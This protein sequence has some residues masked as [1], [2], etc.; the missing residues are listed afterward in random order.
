MTSSQPPDVSL[1]D[2]GAPCPIAPVLAARLRESRDELTARWLERIVARVNLDPNRVFPTEELLDHVPMLLVGIA[3]YIENPANELGADVAVLAKA[4]ELGELRF[5]QGFDA[6]EILKEY[7]IFG[8]ILF[9]FLAREAEGAGGDCTRA[10]LMTCSHRLYRAISVVQR[11]TTIQYLR[12][13]GES[14]GEREDRLRAFHRA[15]S[16]EFKNQIHAALGASQALALEGIP[17]EDS[18]RLVSVVQDSMMAMRSRLEALLSLTAIESDSRRTRHVRLPQAVAEV[19]R[20]LREMASAGEVEVR[21]DA[22]LPKVEVHAAAV[23]LCLANYLSNSIKYS[24]PSKAERWVAVRGA[25]REYGDSHEL[26]VSVHD[27]GCGVGI[28]TRSRLFGRFERAG[29]TTIEGSGLGLSIVRET[30]ESLGGRAWA[31]FPTEGAVFAF[32]LPCRRSD[33]RGFDEADA[34][35]VTDA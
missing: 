13:A 2:I 8:G 10:Q 33:E 34:A 24:D 9:T 26:V 7:E 17:R 15:L 28:D 20:S 3:N 18:Q 21:V 5:R 4:M 31:E 35:P 25:V 12:R 32:S 23:E 19:V 16:H 14:I 11:A 6:Y 29:D 27:N 1:G 22:E 30:V